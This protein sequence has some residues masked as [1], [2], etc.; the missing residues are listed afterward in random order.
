MSTK[1]QIKRDQTITRFTETRRELLEAAAELPPEARDEVFLGTW[2]VRDLLAHLVGW[3][4]TNL[5]AARELVSGRQPTFLSRYDDDWKTY[6]AALVAKYKHNDWGEMLSA[7]E[8]S[9]HRL[10]SFLKSLPP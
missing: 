10:V 2:S 1:S 7:L 5:E 3:D 6:N 4:Y 8:E 9:Q